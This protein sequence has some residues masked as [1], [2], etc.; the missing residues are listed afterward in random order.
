[1]FDQ[2]CIDDCRTAADVI[3]RQQRVLELRRALDLAAAARLGVSASPGGV[4]RR[5]PTVRL[6]LDPA[7]CD[8]AIIAAVAAAAGADRHTLLTASTADMAEGRRLAAAIIM[9]TTG[10]SRGSV[11]LQLGLTPGSVSGAVQRLDGEVE[12]QHIALLGSLETIVAAAWPAFR[13]A[14]WRVTMPAILEAVAEAWGLPVSALKS[15][16]RHAAE[17]A[18]RQIACALAKALT[19]MTLSAIGRHLG[20]RDH[21]TV[22]HA[23]RKYG[24]MVDEVLAELGRN[25]GLDAICARLCARIS[26]G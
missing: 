22:L 2:I 7:Q 5:P 4:A 1:M 24:P 14:A 12:T 3:H 11:A 20:D 15:I 6:Y 18:A 19:P 9:R 8:D 25:A 17:A 21:T 23:V 16:R 13:A 10:R 26:D